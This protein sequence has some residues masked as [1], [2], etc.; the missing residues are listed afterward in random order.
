MYN[1]LAQ[2]LKATREDAS[3]EDVFGKYFAQDVLET[4]HIMKVFEEYMGAATED[5]VFAPRQI[6]QMRTAKPEQ[7]PTLQGLLDDITTFRKNCSAAV[8]SD[9]IGIQRRAVEWEKW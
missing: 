2:Q 4:E 3:F 9:Y 6:A 8:L 7:R 5:S 1:L